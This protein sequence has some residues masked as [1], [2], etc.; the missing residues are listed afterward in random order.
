MILLKGETRILVNYVTQLEYGMLHIMTKSFCIKIS[1]LMQLE[2]WFELRTKLPKNADLESSE[3]N[4]TNRTTT[5]FW[6]S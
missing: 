1:I 3:H 6:Y 4:V 2:Q 5:G